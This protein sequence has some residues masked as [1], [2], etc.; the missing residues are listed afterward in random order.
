V[1]PPGPQQSRT[2]RPSSGAGRR[3]V[4][5]SGAGGGT[6]YGR[7][8][9]IQAPIADLD[10]YA[11]RGMKAFDAPGLAIGIV[12]GDKLVYA[13]GFGVRGKGGGQPVDARTIFQIGSTTKAFLETGLAIMV[14]R[15]MLNW[16]DRVVDL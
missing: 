12:A 8:G 10:A 11:T 16:E 4:A 14:D 5:E 1:K 7:R 9:H 13:K 15:G 3:R 6:L 2:R